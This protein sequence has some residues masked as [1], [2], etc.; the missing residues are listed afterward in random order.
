MK[1]ILS[2]FIK[3]NTTLASLV[4]AFFTLGLIVLSYELY[5]SNNS[6]SWLPYAI[7]IVI[8]L[9]FYFIPSIIGY[10]KKNGVAIFVLNLLLGWTILGWIIALIWACCKD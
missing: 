10:R 5:N 7:L 6:F 8:G 3:E 2:N 4:L 9:D 1:T